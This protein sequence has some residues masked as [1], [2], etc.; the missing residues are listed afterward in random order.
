MNGEYAMAHDDDDDE[1]ACTAGLRVGI[2]MCTC[3]FGG[4]RV[5]VGLFT[6]ATSFEA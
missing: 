4:F 6:H 5:V 2:M 3:A 1:T